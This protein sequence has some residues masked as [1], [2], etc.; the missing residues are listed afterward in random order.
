MVTTKIKDLNPRM[1]NVV[2]EAEVK[3]KEIVTVSS[4]PLAKALIKDDT[5]EIVLNLWRDQIDQVKVGDRIVVREGFVRLWN[6]KPELNTWS[7]IEVA[8]AKTQ[9]DVL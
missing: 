2:I 6:G 5:G 8:N 3:S 7:R 1:R 9:K 4:K